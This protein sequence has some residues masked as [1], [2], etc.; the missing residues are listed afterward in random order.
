MLPA[1]IL[2]ILLSSVDAPTLSLTWN[3]MSLGT[4]LVEPT[5]GNRRSS[6][7]SFEPG[8]TTLKN[9]WFDQDNIT[10][11][12]QRERIGV[13]SNEDRRSVRGVNGGEIQYNL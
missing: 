3:A 1:V 10:G 13:E 8:A 6:I 11:G 9:C 4:S 7:G 2:T 5:L 12:A